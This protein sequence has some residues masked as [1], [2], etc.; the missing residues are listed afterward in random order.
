MDLQDDMQQCCN[1]VKCQ[2]DHSIEVVARLR[3]LQIDEPFVKPVA[4][5][6]TLVRCYFVRANRRCCF[7]VWLF[8]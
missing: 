5:D 4:T 3:K 2:L 8:V 7:A 1:L 6:A